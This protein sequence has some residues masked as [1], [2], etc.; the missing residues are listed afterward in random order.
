MSAALVWGRPS[1]GAGAF[2]RLDPRTRFL[3]LLLVLLSA[4]LARGASA[5]AGMAVLAGLLERPL[6]L[7]RGFTAA[8]LRLAA[9]P[10][11]FTLILNW[12]Y[13]PGSG[14]LPRPALA[15]LH[16]G[17]LN[18]L[19]LWVTWQAFSVFWATT[20][21]DELL[22]ALRGGG[23]RPPGRLQDFRLTLELALRFAPLVGEE[24][25]RLL[26]AQKARGARWGGNPATR[27]F[28]A[29][30]L[31]AP[32]VAGCMRRAEALADTLVARGYGSGPTTRAVDYRLGARDVAALA[33]AALAV[34]LAARLP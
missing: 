26:L 28:Q 6:K 16:N 2:T 11:A 27:A 13:S 7:P 33:V 1:A 14:F 23:A 24:A 8:M 29:A 12:L 31:V 5:L 9:W 34:A 25:E 3:L 22:R 32:L 10:L 19:R 21:P 20:S 17:A 18:A 15:G 30:G 4:A